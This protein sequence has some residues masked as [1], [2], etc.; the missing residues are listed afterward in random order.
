[1]RA[2]TTYEADGLGHTVDTRI[3]AE[4]RYI[5]HKVILP[6]GEHVTVYVTR[7]P[8]GARLSVDVGTNTNVGVRVG[9]SPVVHVSAGTIG[10]LLMSQAEES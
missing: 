2:A 3:H 5:A 7:T 9:A 1:M 6:G 4:G 10:A 8:G